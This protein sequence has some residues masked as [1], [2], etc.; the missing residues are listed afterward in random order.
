MAAC[1]L[2]KTLASFQQQQQLQ[3]L[4]SFNS[5]VGD[6]TKGSSDVNKVVQAVGGKK[7]KKDSTIAN[8]GIGAA[9]GLAKSL[10]SAFQQ[11]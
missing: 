1:E 10:E 2:A 6:V 4:F 11:Q 5:I 3:E 7:A 8:A 9:G